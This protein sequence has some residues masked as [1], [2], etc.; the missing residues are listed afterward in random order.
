MLKNARAPN[1]SI[2]VNTSLNKYNKL[3]SKQIFLY[4]TRISESIVQ[5]IHAGS[6][7]QK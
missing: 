6:Y 7:K 4:I 5:L 3:I 2:P 1:G